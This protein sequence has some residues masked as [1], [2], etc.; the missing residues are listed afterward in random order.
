MNI[1]VISALLGVAVLGAATMAAQT[2]WH[3]HIVAGSAPSGTRDGQGA[4]AQFEF[5]DSEHVVG[6]ALDS[7]GA[8]YVSDAANHSIRKISPTGQVTTFA[9][10]TTAGYVDAAGTNA[11]FTF[12]QGLAIDGSDNLYVADDNAIRRITP[13]GVVSTWALAPR[14]RGLAIAPD[15][16]LYT[17]GD[18]RLLRRIN[19]DRT[20]TVVA[21][22]APAGAAGSSP[23]DGT[24]SSA[25]FSLIL[26]VVRHPGTGNIYV[27][28]RV[29]RHPLNLGAVSSVIRVVTPTGVVTTVPSQFGGRLHLYLPSIEFST[30]GE[31]LLV[32]GTVRCG[33]REPC[34]T[35]RILIE[36]GGTIHEASHA[37]LVPRPQIRG[38]LRL[39]NGSF[40]AAARSSLEEPNAISSSILRLTLTNQSSTS[41]PGPFAAAYTE[42]AGRPEACTGVV[43]SDGTRLDTRFCRIRSIAAGPGD[44]MFVT[45]SYPWRDL[46]TG[47]TYVRGYTVRRIDASGQSTTL[48]GVL[49]ATGSTD[50]AASASRF[51]PT[52]T[53]LGGPLPIAGHPDGSA[54]VAD[55]MNSTIRQISASGITT[56]IAGR[57]AQTGSSDGT[58]TSARFNLPHGLAVAPSGDIYVADTGNA[59]IRRIGADGVVSTVAGLPQVGGSTDGHGSG[60]RFSSPFGIAAAADGTLYVA[61]TGNHTIRRIDPAGQVTTLAGSPG[62]SGNT[63]GTGA[64]ARFNTPRTLALSPDGILFVGDRDTDTGSTTNH[65]IRRVTPSGDVTTIR[66]GHGDVGFVDASGRLHIPSG[67]TVLTLTPDEPTPPGVTTQP[68]SLTRSP[69]QSAAFSVAVSGQP[70]ATLQWQA[71]TDNGATW[72][73]LS[74]SSTVSGSTGATLTLSNVAVA[75]PPLRVRVVAHNTF[76]D[77]TSAE[78]VLTVAGLS[79]APASLRFRVV[80]EGTSGLIQEHPAQILRVAFVGVAPSALSWSADQPWI[81]LQTVGSA[82]ARGVIMSSPQ[83]LTA[84]STVTGTITIAAVGGSSVQIPVTLDVLA[85]GTSSAPIGQVDTPT[86]SATV[87]GTVAF[88]GWAT[89]DV[90]VSH[91]SIYRGCVDGEGATCSQGFIPGRPSERVVFL[92]SVVP[93]EGARPDVEA[94]FQHNPVGRGAGWGFL[95]LSNMLPRTTGTYSPHGGQGPI[96]LFAVAHDFDGHQSLLGRHYGSDATPTTVVLDND[97]LATPFGAID[98]PEQGARLS[99][100]THQNFGWV[101]TPDSDTVAGPGDIT[102]PAAGITAFIDGRA[103]GTVSYDHCRG[104]V[105]NPVPTSTFC[106]DDVANAFGRTTAGTGPRTSNPTKY[107]NLDAGRG[108]IGAFTLDLSSLANGQHTLAWG[109]TD[110]NGRSAGIGSRFLFIQRDEADQTL[111]ATA[112]SHTRPEGPRATVGIWGREGFDPHRA[113]Q[114]LAPTPSGTYRVRIQEMGRLELWF[115]TA[116]TGVMVVGDSARPLPPGSHLDES[117]GHFSWMPGPGFLGDYHL[118][119]QRGDERV[120]VELTIEPSRTLSL[121]EPEIDMTEL[122]IQGSRLITGRARDPRAFHGHGIAAVHVWG[123]RLG[124]SSETP[125]FLGEAT[126]ASDGTYTFD[127]AELTPG[128]WMRVT[129]Y[130]LATRTGRFEDARTILVGIR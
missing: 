74:N 62:Q 80:K 112:R 40:A 86:Q 9:G 94:L 52:D 68:Q 125:V 92:G 106:D 29:S 122:S 11:R 43:A 21:G 2:Q 16:S 104:T 57:A 45:D 46:S 41:T 35:P 69:G 82:S 66:T 103:V 72:S 107:R 116:A 7:A 97:N 49:S 127:V 95:I 34:S 88:T 24:G 117:R 84:P 30:A 113:F 20:T 58:G 51:G 15:G 114:P 33:L 53:R 93:T 115:G 119:F 85:P 36:A 5:G 96:T 60:A 50:G 100:L 55:P 79:V 54:I 65:R 3:T 23:V 61:D 17:G 105:G 44:S 76:G 10:Q 63:D 28:D 98:V 4:A 8:I 102:V 90:G 42:L 18:D 126:I 128:N 56:T 64:S 89:D 22:G 123:W 31:L 118:S 108:A 111:G 38:L 91:V 37:F 99:V 6:M 120:D 130:A 110:S 39:A 81:T 83:N 77:V 1:R 67:P 73:N 71:S 14:G 75:A 32:E 87:S 12:P 26:H 124:G 27:V 48:A 101:L 59:T 109:V 47:I 19:P 70:T 13:T 25:E 78:A 129:A 121:V